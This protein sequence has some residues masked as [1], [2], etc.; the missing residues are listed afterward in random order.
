[1][2]IKICGLCRRQDIVYVNEALPDF[3]G[4][5]FWQKSRRYIAKE[6]AAVLK[7]KLDSR[8][9]AVGVFVDEAP[10]R[11]LSLLLSGVI[12]IAQLHGKETEGEIRWLQKKSGKPVWKAV[13]VKDAASVERWRF[14]QADF[15]LFDGGMGEGRTFLWENLSGFDRA[16]FLAGGITAENLKEI[17]ENPYLA[18]IDVSSGVETEGVKDGAKIK[19]F[20]KEVRRLQA[21]WEKEHCAAVE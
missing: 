12:D 7:K 1:M 16:F 13:V 18:G 15:I 3:A 6:Q 17:K 20:V 10:D 21:E 4:F 8:I 5:V 14:S 19:L 2:R 9:Q 11:I